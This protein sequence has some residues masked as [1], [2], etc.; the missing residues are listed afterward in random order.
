VKF[1]FPNSHFVFLHDTPSKSLF[2]R[3]ERSFSSGC[4]R[5]ENP[6]EFA[7]LL[8]DDP[9]KWNADTIQQM[10]DSEKPRTVFLKE[11]MTVML[12]YST[13]GV[14][15]EEVVRFYN[16]IYQRDARVLE[17]L[18]GDFEFSLPADAPAYVNQ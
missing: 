4:I 1:I 13:V 6:F 5:V 8:L 10:L 14:A 18:D 3:T 16:D 12:L 11:P 17:P 9:A 2:E 15:D 7:E